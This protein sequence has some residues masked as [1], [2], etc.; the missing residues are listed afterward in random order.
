MLE[1]HAQFNRIAD[2]FLEEHLLVRRGAGRTAGSARAPAA[3][4]T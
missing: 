2:D 1:R 3:R 4:D